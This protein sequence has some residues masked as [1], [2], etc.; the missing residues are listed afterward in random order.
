MEIEQQRALALAQARRRR[1][2][3]ERAASPPQEAP[4]EPIS[5][6][7]M[8]GGM[9]RAMAPTV[10]GAAGGAVLGGPP[11]AG[12]G[13][14]AM[15]IAALADQLFG[16]NT[17]EK[18][19]DKLGV[20]KAKTRAEKLGAAA[21]G[22]LAGMTG[23]TGAAARIAD[24]AVNP[25]VKETA[26]V[27]ASNPGMGATSAVTGGLASETARQEGAGPTGEFVAGMAGAAAP[28][29]LAAT[30]P[31]AGRTVWNALKD[32]GAAVGA[33]TG[34]KG[35]ITKLSGDVVENLLKNSDKPAIRQALQEATTYV[36]GA[37][38][39]VAEAMAEAN[40]KSPEKQ[41]GGALVKLQDTISGNKGVED[42][43]PSKMKANQAAVDSYIEDHAG[44]MAIL[45]NE[46]FRQARQGPTGQPG[47]VTGKGPVWGADPVYVHK[48]AA[49]A[50]QD[51]E[52]AGHNLA[53]KLISGVM[54]DL[55][56][57]PKNQFGMLDPEVM[58]GIRQSA[59]ARLSKLLKDEMTPNDAVASKALRR[60]QDSMDDAIGAA[61]PGWK[62]YMKLYSKGMEP[63]NK[64]T[65]RLAEA[66]SMV[67][68]ITGR[69]VGEMVQETM[70]SIPGLLHRPTM[71]ARFLLH[72]VAKDAADPITRDIAK[73]LEDPEQFLQLM[74]RPDA[75][76]AKK[77]LNQ[78]LMHAAILSNL[79]QRH[80]AEQASPP[81]Q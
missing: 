78:T 11:G 35:S 62:E 51:R 79:I 40:L 61:A 46:A 66:N 69:G 32:A 76:P 8:A 65:A 54:T 34:H 21:A 15:N 74:S 67:E 7:R 75:A 16:L 45:R 10:L 5:Y 80:Q 52:I 48:V 19:A 77:A 38:P 37:K 60:L 71:V 68:G 26:K 81:V 44:R 4:E 56:K 30:V 13:A 43:L 36:P 14:V 55:K 24:T 47:L 6:E 33:I 72:L 27:V 57:V 20:P 39:T 23:M 73:R 59:G 18:L 63:V 22:S 28:S 58:Y 70:P 41:V 50:L 64:H 3:A 1:A 25:V 9:G 31:A 12:I 29:V 49:H 17:I 53:R 42:V 2:E